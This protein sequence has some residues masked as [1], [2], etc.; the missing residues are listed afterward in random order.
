MISDRLGCIFV[1]IPKCGGTSLEDVIW[2]GPRD[3]AE[4]WMGFV[5]RYHNR[6]Q[7]GGLQHLTA[8]LIREAVGPARFAACWKF[9]LVR[10]PFDR[11]VSQYAFMRHRPDLRDFI[12]MAADDDFA[13]YLGLIARRRHVQWMPQHEF[14]CDAE[15][16]IMVDFIGR[17]ENLAA[18]ARA[19]LARLGLGA[20]ALQHANR[21]ERGDWR[22]YYGPAERRMVETLHARDLDLFGYAF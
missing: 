22:A 5:D 21:G 13:T 6:Y 17:F 11:L 9:A 16:R 7:T 10:N 8:R 18:D 15:G 3:E 19:I 2:P 1:H 14:L 20:V 4:L 12:G